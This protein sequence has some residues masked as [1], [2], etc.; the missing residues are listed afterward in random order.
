R[1]RLRDALDVAK[2]HPPRIVSGDLL[3]E[4][5]RLAAQAPADATLVIFHSAVLSYLESA[6]RARFTDL[7][8]RLPGR[9]I[10]NEGH[11]V[12]KQLPLPF[13][14]AWASG[15]FIH[16]LDGEPGGLSAPQGRE[17]TGLR[18]G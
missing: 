11:G 9:W 7:V 17:S 12:A 14:P 13:Q 15:G 2:E 1:Q 4:L 16:A 8:R 10:S 5:P 3:G 18:V 6:D